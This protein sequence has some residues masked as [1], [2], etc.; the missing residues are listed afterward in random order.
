MRLQSHPNGCGPSTVANILRTLGFRTPSGD[1]PSEDWVSRKAKLS[2][3][4][5]DP[6]PGYGTIEWQIRRCLESLNVPH[7]QFSTSDPNLAAASLR[8]FLASGW[9]VMLAVDNDEHWVGAIGLVGERV[10]VADSADGE[11]VVVY[12][13]EQ[14]V[15]RWATATDPAK[16]YGIVV[17]GKKRGRRG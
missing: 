15:N 5:N 7:F 16:F 4:M 17:T 6:H 3:A 1:D 2:A 10:L 9:P 11:L 13:T 12:D 14:V 8:G